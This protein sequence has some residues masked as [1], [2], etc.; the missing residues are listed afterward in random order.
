MKKTKAENNFRGK[1]G[2]LENVRGLAGYLKTADGEPI[3]LTLIVNNFLVP[4]QL[5]NYVQDK[6]CNILS[7][8]NRK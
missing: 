7:N 5:A 4:S 2:F 3:A 8:F 6:V 1:S